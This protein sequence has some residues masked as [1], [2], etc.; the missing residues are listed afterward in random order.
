MVRP[1]WFIGDHFKGVCSEPPLKD[2]YTL[3][4]TANNIKDDLHFPNTLF[5]TALYKITEGSK[6]KAELEQ[7]KMDAAAFV[8]TPSP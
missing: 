6:T 7:E 5:V 3:A 4:S 1:R 2:T 8:L